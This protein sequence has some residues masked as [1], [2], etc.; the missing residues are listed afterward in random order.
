MFLFWESLFII[1]RI[2]WFFL[3]IQMDN[4][5]LLIGEFSLHTLT[6]M[7]GVGG[8]RSIPFLCFPFVSSLFP[9]FLLLAA[10]WSIYY[11]ISPFL[12]CFFY[13]YLLENISLWFLPQQ[14]MKEKEN[15]CGIC[16]ILVQ[17]LFSHNKKQNC[18]QYL[19]IYH[20]KVSLQ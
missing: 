20:R 14:Y 2:V 7:T 8:F 4:P 13:T 12:P 17:G 19:T 16:N 11:Y 10:F 18:I 5:C 9:L 15:K 1:S 3:L 6:I